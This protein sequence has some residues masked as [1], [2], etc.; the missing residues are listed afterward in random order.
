MRVL[1]LLVFF[2]LTSVFTVSSTFSY[3]VV[4]VDQDGTKSL[5]S[6]C[7]TREEAEAQLFGSDSY[8]VYADPLDLLF[9]L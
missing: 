9:T 8:V 6:T 4:D 7:N 2:T 3:C 1:F 5:G